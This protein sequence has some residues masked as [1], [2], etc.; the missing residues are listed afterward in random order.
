MT[1]RMKDSKRFSSDLLQQIV[2]D[3]K[4]ATPR[5]ICMHAY[6]KYNLHN[7]NWFDL[8]KTFF[9]FITMLGIDFLWEKWEPPTQDQQELQTQARAWTSISLLTRLVLSANS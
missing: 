2:N 6:F 9:N 3:V 8:F 1:E 7:R 5:V 4:E